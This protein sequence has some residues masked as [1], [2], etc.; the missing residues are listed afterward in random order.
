L[1]IVSGND[2]YAILSGTSMAAPHVAGIAAL[3]WQANP[4]LTGSQMRARLRASTDAVGAA[5]NDSWGYGKVN[6]LK[7]VAS[8]VASIADPGAT[9][10]NGAAL[11]LDGSD[12]SAA[13]GAPLSLSWSLSTKPAGS[14]ASLSGSSATAVLTPDLPGDY[15]VSL[16]ATQS[17]VPA[18]VA[19]RTIRA[20]RIPT[21]PVVTAPSSFGNAAPV[22]FSASAS[23]P[24]G[25]SLAWDWRL[26]SRP[27]G[28]GATLSP[29][30]AAA[31]LFPDV[32]GSYVVGARANDGLG[33]SILGTGTFTV[34][35][36]SPAPVPPGQGSS[37][38][39]CAIS[40]GG[41]LPGGAGTALLLGVAIFLLRRHRSC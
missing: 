37:G 2:D 18:A 35:V 28:S 12:S 25:V 21:T 10:P 36:V 31:T 22:V 16:T 17:G 6:A 41:S 9:V 40:P 8:T 14:A 26:V 7:A 29:A 39:G 23:D 19:S 15:V 24:E 30:G 3:A 11:T 1:A 34:G 20:N 4:A 27:E 32:P 33:S 13:F 5:P 38:G